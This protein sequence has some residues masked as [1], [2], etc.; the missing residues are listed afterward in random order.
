MHMVIFLVKPEVFLVGRR[1][2]DPE[3]WTTKTATAALL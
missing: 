3:L 1:G 2:S